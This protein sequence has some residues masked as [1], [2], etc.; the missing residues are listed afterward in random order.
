M[1]EVSDLTERL[2]EFRDLRRW[3]QFHNPKDLALSVTLE[4][5][6]L[7][8]LFQWK[9]A[10]EVASL[11]SEE[12]FLQKARDEIAD[13]LIYLLLLS[14][15]LNIDA[16]GSAWDKVGKNEIRFPAQTT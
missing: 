14:H 8:E 7:L 5:A 12:A 2:I 16:V 10:D 9:S 6:E 13:V 15:E 1:S 3:K 4:S 11:I